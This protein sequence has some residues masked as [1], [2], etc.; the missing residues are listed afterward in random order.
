MNSFVKVL[1]LIAIAIVGCQESQTKTPVSHPTA[2][3]ECAV[4]FEFDNDSINQ[5]E[6]VTIVISN[7]YYT[8]TNSEEGFCIPKSANP[9]LSSFRNYRQ[10][11]L[12]EPNNSKGKHLLKKRRYLISN[13]KQDHHF[14]LEAALDPVKDSVILKETMD[15]VNSMMKV[16]SDFWNEGSTDVSKT[17][18]SIDSISK[19]HGSVR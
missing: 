8:C 13:H 1:C 11:D 19:S 3:S 17:I 12:I 6:E 7:Q 2:S 9:N 4:T 18:R 5:L 10:V 16:T 14:Y 15:M